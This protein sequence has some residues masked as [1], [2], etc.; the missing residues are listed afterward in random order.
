MGAFDGSSPASTPTLDGR[1]RN[2]ENSLAA[3][4]T[5]NINQGL[6]A[7]Q[8]QQVANLDPLYGQVYQGLQNYNATGSNQQAQ[9]G[10]NAG[11]SGNPSFNPTMNFQ[12]APTLDPSQ[13]ASYFQSAVAN[14]AM[15][16]Y[17]QNTAPAI[18]AAFAGQGATFSTRR[19]LAQQQ[20]LQNMNTSLNSQL[21]QAQLSNQQAQYNMQGQFG[22]QQNQ[23]GY[24]LQ[25]LQGS[26]A[27]SAAQ[28]QQSAVGQQQQQAMLPYQQALA[29][30]QALNPYQQQAQNQDTSAYN[31]FL[32]DQPY[33]SPY[34]Q[35]AFSLLGQNTMGLYNNASQ[36]FLSQI[37]QGASAAGGLYGLGQVTGANAGIAGLFATGT[38]AGAEVGSAFGGGLT[39]ADLAAAGLFAAPAGA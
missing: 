8:G 13:T 32:R 20:A 5:P 24:N 3:S 33:N 9:Q 22:Q 17:Q 18:D 10:I 39:A 11:L 36:G 1:Q 31:E 14:P 29:M 19:G 4:I 35:Q 2:I 12:Q 21:G 26:L 30:Q 27:D 37:Q 34:T 28:R 23:L 38:G 16:N 7:Y 25:A 6:P 15:A